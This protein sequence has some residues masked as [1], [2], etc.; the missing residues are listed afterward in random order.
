MGYR[1]VVLDNYHWLKQNDKSTVFP[2]LFNYTNYENDSSSLN[3]VMI[4]ASVM[5]EI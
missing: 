3:I 1:G 2:H 5:P 4:Y